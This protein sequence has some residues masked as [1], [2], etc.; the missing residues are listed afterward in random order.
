VSG[1][2]ARA[3]RA[4]LAVCLL[5]VLVPAPNAAAAAAA[6]STDATRTRL[7][8]QGWDSPDAVRLRWISITTW[9]AS[10]GGHVVLFDSSV[11]DYLAQ[12]EPGTDF[13]SLD[14]VIAARPEFIYQ[15]HGHIDHLRHAAEIA[16]A[17]GARLVGSKDH[18]DVT[19]RQADLKGIG[20]GKIHCVAVREADGAEFTGN[21]TY[22]LP[23]EPGTT[24]FGTRGKPDDGPPGLE[25]TAVKIKHTQ[26]RPYPDTLVGPEGYEADPS[27]YSDAPPT[28]QST[29]EVALYFDREG[30]SLLYV[31]RYGD[32]T[33]ANHDST[34][35]L[36]SPEPG[37]AAIRSAL[38]A[39]GA[40]DRVDIEIG[41]I[42]ELQNYTNGLVDAQRYAEAIGA[43]VFFPQHHGNWNPPATSRAAAYY[44]PW[45]R[46]M[47]EIPA[48]RRP[49]LCFVTE[50]NR[51]TAFALRPSDWAGDA[52]GPVAP[53]GGPGCYGG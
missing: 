51:A 38:Q 32:L 11:M 5:S 43:K 1:R 53:L 2:L 10:F 49:A 24:P 22:V 44:E 4:V 42:A 16:A 18:C 48:D 40:Q 47:A 23:V 29:L 17:T 45:R 3:T 26:M 33:I 34:G 7:L 50:A 39:L 15:G 6:E 12:P 9:L 13:V 35:P 36:T 46:R 37:R 27:P 8:G 21:D 28:P 41:A 25:V 14:D 31:F 30:G 19:K 20:A 52:S